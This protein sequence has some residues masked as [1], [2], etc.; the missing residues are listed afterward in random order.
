MASDQGFHDYAVERLSPF[1]DITSRSMFGGW[2]LFDQDVM[3]ALISGA[4]LYFKVDD[5]TRAAYEAAGS[6]SYGR[7]P[8]YEVPGD[9]LEDAARLESWTTE[10]I[11][12]A[13]AAPKKP[14]RGMPKRGPKQAPTK[15]G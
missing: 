7:M 13:H 10:A 9:V 3:F 5:S 8:Y 2:G 1:G 11:A 6:E 12:V 15:S 4:S 14:P